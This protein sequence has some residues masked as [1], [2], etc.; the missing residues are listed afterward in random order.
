MTRT[1]GALADRLLSVV[2]PRTTASAV[3]QPTCTNDPMCCRFT[4]TRFKYRTCNSSC[5]CWWG[6]DC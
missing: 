2:L 1:V 3:C 6:S 5:V 4:N